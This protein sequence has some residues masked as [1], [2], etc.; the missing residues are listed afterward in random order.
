[1]KNKR[2]TILTVCLI[3]TSVIFVGFSLVNN[4]KVVLGLETLDKDV[5]VSQSL[6]KGTG[7]KLSQTEEKKLES[8]KAEIDRLKEEEKKNAEKSSDSKPPKENSNSNDMLDNMD[9]NELINNDKAGSIV[10]TDNISSG[11]GNKPGEGNK[12]SDSDKGGGNSGSGDRGKPGKDDKPDKDKNPKP[13]KPDKPTTDPEEDLRPTIETT[14]KESYRDPNFRFQIIA[15]D[16]YGHPITRLVDG[17]YVLINGKSVYAENIT[18][19]AGHE[20]KMGV[21]GQLKDGTNEI[22]IKIVDSKGRY[23]VVKYITVLNKNT[24]IPESEMMT[25]YMSLDMRNVGLGT[26]LYYIPYKVEKGTPASQIIYN[27]LTDYGYTV[28]YT[29]SMDYSFYLS[30]ISKP[31]ITNG[32]HIPDNMKE[33]LKEEGLNTF[34]PS[35]FSIKPNSLGEKDT[36][37]T[38]SGWC[39]AYCACRTDGMSKVFPNDGENLVV[40]YTNYYGYDMF[41]IWNESM[42]REYEL[43]P[44]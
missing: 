8:E 12:P 18:D 19:G 39:Y 29:G 26:P 44:P 14:I 25:V 7:Y 16:H 40:F 20:I 31:G 3:V 2:Y 32:L 27:F 24:V 36:Y 34:D 22:E 42:Y 41:G 5:K 17:S 13:N 11:K 4:G 43:S 21:G 15:K 10:N 37:P 35:H 30:R 1:M 33:H 6:L 28:T 9:E 38:S 23:R